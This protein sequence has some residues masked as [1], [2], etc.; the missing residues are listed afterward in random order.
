MIALFE[1][2][3]TLL[4]IGIL[5]NLWAINGRLEKVLKRLETEK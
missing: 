5:W 1:A 3:V 4:L 2:A